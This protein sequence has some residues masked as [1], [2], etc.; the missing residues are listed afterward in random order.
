MKAIGIASTAI[1]SLLFGIAAPV[2][3]Q[4]QRGEKEEHSQQQGGHERGKPEQQHAQQ[5]SPNSS[6]LSSSGS[7][8]MHSSNTRTI[9][10][11]RLSGIVNS[12][13]CRNSSV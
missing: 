3:A 9:S 13:I 11:C 7:Q 1:L 12:G 5:P 6:M 2:Y 8:S 10:S 4:E